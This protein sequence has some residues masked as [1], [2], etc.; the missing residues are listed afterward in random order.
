MIKFYIFLKIKKIFFHFIEKNKK[1]NCKQIYYYFF[2]KESDDV[3]LN[4]FLI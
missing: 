1:K 3:K 4:F 2:F